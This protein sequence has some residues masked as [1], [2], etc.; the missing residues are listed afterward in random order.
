MNGDFFSSVNGSSTPDNVIP[1]G[2]GFGMN[3]SFSRST[4]CHCLKL[5]SVN[6]NLRLLVTNFPSVLVNVESFSTR[7]VK[8]EKITVI[9]PFFD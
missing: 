9:P 6:F 3:G 5:N 8:F 1:G 2:G 4:V 7:G